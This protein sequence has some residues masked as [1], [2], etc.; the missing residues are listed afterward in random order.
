MLVKGRAISLIYRPGNFKEVI[1]EVDEVIKPFQF[2]KNIFDT[3][4]N[5]FN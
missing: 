5:E 4:V 3:I 2:L 1:L